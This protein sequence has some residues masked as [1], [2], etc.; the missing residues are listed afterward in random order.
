MPNLQ[1]TT[2]VRADEMRTATEPVTVR[3]L[4]KSFGDTQVLRGVDLE[5]PAGSI[6]SL[7]GPS[8]CGKTTLLRSIAGLE[9]PD[10]GQVSI[11]DRVVSG[12]GSFVAPEH[13]RVGMVFQDWALFPHLSVERNVAFGL[14]RFDRK[15][16]RVAETLEM[17]GLEALA[18]RMPAELSGGQQ[19]RVALARALATRPEVILLDEPYSNLDS[20]LRAQIRF[21]V[22][23]LLSDLGITTLFVTHDQEEAFVMGE[24]VAVMFDGVVLQQ[25]RPSEIYDTPATRR[26]AHFIGDANFFAGSADG[27]KADTQVGMIPLLH[28]LHGDVEVMVRPEYITVVPGNEATV[29]SVEFYGHDSIYWVQPDEQPALRARV[30]STPEFGPGDRVSLGYGGGSAPAY[31]V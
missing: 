19:Q 31:R 17:V 8:G 5:I 1:S 12:V 27:D 16:S 18:Q 29:E 21:E 4:D 13:R 23:R 15:S 24:Y 25:G 20:I 26:V 6:V 22:Q 7:L 28:P 11:G 14:S 2:L 10:S 3:S 30:L 9:R